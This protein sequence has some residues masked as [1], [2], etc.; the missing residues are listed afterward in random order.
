[1]SGVALCDTTDPEKFRLDML[2]SLQSPITKQS[3]NPDF[4]Q[5]VV[6]APDAVVIKDVRLTRVNVK[7]GLREE[8]PD[9]PINPANK[10]AMGIVEK[11][12]GPDGINVYMGTVG[13]RA[14]VIY[15]SDAPTLES[16]I[17]AAQSNT[18]ALSNN[19]TI[20]ATR[21]QLV[22]NPVAVAYLP[23]TRWLTLAQAIIHPPAE[24]EPPPSP[25]IVNA[26]PVVI[27]TGVDG[28]M[29]TSEIHVPIATVQGAQ[30]AYQRLRRA[31][32]GGG[33][34]PGAPLP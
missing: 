25:A 33:A 2:E 30:E 1:L 27:S 21:D 5:S 15:G 20:A 23:I 34:N 10:A 29:V 22:A 18:D 13:K 7:M 12:Y 26:P 24:G 3:F 8:T 11:I 6:V 28:S 4:R 32:M 19:P 31:F 14:I 16:A 17:A 9:K